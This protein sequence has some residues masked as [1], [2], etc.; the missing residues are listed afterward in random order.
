MSSA[1]SCLRCSGETVESRRIRLNPPFLTNSG[2]AVCGA[3]NDNSL[4]TFSR[5]LKTD[6]PQDPFRPTSNTFG[7][8]T[9]V[10]TL[11]CEVI[12]ESVSNV[13]GT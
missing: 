7:H 9:A 4:L 12:E 2:E 1:A 13:A 8:E 6:V 5:D 11:D 3:A 10:A